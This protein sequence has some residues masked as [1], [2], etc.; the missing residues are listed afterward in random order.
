MNQI[1]MIYCGSLDL[2]LKAQFQRSMLVSICRGLNSKIRRGD[3]PHEYV[4]ETKLYE[5]KTFR[6]LSRELGRR[7][8]YSIWVC[9]VFFFIRPSYWNGSI[10]M[11]YSWS[12]VSS[13]FIAVFHQL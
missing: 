7:I 12:T 6:W 4:G 13:A 10:N 9:L 8:V 11:V 2:A 3:I 5:L 1:H